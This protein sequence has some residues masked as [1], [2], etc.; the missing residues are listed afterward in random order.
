[1]VPFFQQIVNGFEIVPAD[2]G[3]L[4][5]KR[6]LTKAASAEDAYSDF[7]HFDI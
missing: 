1:M 5:A 7:D 3:C 4:G 6:K 2:R